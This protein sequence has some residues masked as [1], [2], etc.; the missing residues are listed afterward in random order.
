[1]RTKKNS[2]Y[3]WDKVYSKYNPTQLPW[4]NIKFP[5]EVLKQVYA[6]DKSK[7][8]LV[9]SCG[10]GDTANTFYNMGFK[11]V[12]GTDISEKA[13]S[14]AKKRFPKLK[15]ETVET[16]SL[17]K[18]GYADVNVFDWVNLHHITKK[19]LKPY[20]L[21]LQRICDVLILTYIFEPELGKIRESYITGGIVYNHNP[22]DIIKILNKLVLQNQ[23]KFT[24]KI[25][26]K[27]GKRTHRAITLVFKK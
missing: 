26:P 22:K 13:I 4:F 27:F 3:T 20:L 21:S 2:R 9:P 14:T 17:Y 10:A 25:N 11:N 5:K 24:F 23:F 18:K 15:F 7:T 6:L 8:I 1:M 16:G 19:N 12:I